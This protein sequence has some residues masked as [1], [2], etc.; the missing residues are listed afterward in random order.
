MRAQFDTE[1]TL[2]MNAIEDL[3]VDTQTIRPKSS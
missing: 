3:F 1:P 2:G